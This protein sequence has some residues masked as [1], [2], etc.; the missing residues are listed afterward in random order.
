MKQKTKRIIFFIL[1]IIN[2]LTIFF[3][4]HQPGDESGLQSNFI[5]EIVAKIL[6]NVEKETLSFV[7]RKTAHFSIY[8]MLGILTMNFTNTTSNKIVKNTIISLIFC[9][10]YAIT[11]EFHQLFIQGRS[12]ELKDVL[13][14]TSG[15]LT[16]ILMVIIISKIYRK[17]KQGET[18]ETIHTKSI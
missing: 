11:D 2:C 18:Y 4:S 8:A 6:P 13:I 7:V 12:G 10:I 15:A 16:G 17:I 9:F 5:V 1:I 3:F 14:D